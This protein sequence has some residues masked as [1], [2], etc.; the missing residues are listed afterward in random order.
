MYKFIIVILNIILLENNN[1]IRFSIIY[2]DVDYHLINFCKFLSFTI[3][4]ID[5]TNEKIMI[6]KDFLIK[7]KLKLLE[8]INI[9]SGMINLV[10]KNNNIDYRDVLDFFELPQ[11]NTNYN[12]KLSN[13]IY[14]NNYTLQYQIESSI[15]LIQKNIPKEIEFNLNNL[16]ILKYAIL[17]F[18]KHKTVKNYK[19]NNPNLNFLNNINILELRLDFQNKLID[20][21]NKLVILKNTAITLKNEINEINIANKITETDIKIDVESE[22]RNYN[23]Y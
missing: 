20:I 17:E 14:N 2:K 23:N 7:N 16:N 8:K 12:N 13:I 1:R 21:I 4:T 22:C 5:N 3:N 19:L 10:I 9:S 6:I 11:L 18:D 15:K